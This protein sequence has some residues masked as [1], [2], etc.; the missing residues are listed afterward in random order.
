MVNSPYCMRKGKSGRRMQ[1]LIAVL[2]SKL[3]MVEVG[4]FTGESAEI[5]LKSGKVELLYAV[6]AWVPWPDLDITEFFGTFSSITE[7]QAYMENVEKVF[8]KRMESFGN[9]VVKM[10][11]TSQEAS[12]RFDLL[13][14]D[15]VYIDASHDYDSVKND[16][17]VWL[18][19]VKVGGMIGGHD[20]FHPPVKKAVDEVFNLVVTFPETS[21]IKTVNRVEMCRS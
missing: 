10:K 12:Q 21:W 17:S 13:S 6:D 5:F 8:D 18:P 2:P 15:F 11:M 19:K 1:S 9:R 7:R 16:I 20:Y 3:V 14:L 4:N